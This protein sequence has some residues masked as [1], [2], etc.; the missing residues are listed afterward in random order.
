MQIIYSFI[1]KVG[2]LRYSK[3]PKT[4]VNAA[5]L[6]RAY[7]FM[8]KSTKQIKIYETCVP[9]LLWL[10]Q[11]IESPPLRPLVVY[12]NLRRRKKNGCVISRK[13]QKIEIYECA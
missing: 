8:L 1:K 13:V 10:I 5:I 12:V 6:I 9:K 2:S 11:H 3:T 7:Y 4:K